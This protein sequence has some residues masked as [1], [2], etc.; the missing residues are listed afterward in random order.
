MATGARE[1][2]IRFIGDSSSLNAAAGKADQSV[3][4]LGLSLTKLAKTG[5]FAMA[6]REMERFA[7]TSFKAAV[8]EQKSQRLLSLA[9]KEVVGATENQAAVVEQNLKKLEQMTGVLDNELRPA[10]T[11]LLR[12]TRSTTEA[13]SLLGLSLDIAA[14]R[15]LD[16]NDVATT[17]GKTYLGV[18]RGV[19]TYGVSMRDANGHLRDFKDVM[20]ELGTIYQGQAKK[21]FD[22]DPAKRLNMEMKNLYESVGKGL[23][24]ALTTLSHGVSDVVGWFD[25]LTPAAQ[26]TATY[27]ALIGGGVLVASR[28]LMLFK[29]TLVGVG[30][31]V[32]TMVPWLLGITAAIAGVV[33][34]VN[35]F[36]DD[37]STATAKQNEFTAS[38]QDA[39]GAVDIQTVALLSAA[40]AA[41]TYSKSLFDKHDQDVRTKIDSTANL[42]AVLADLGINY[43]DVVSSTHSGAAATKMLGDI[44]VATGHRVSETHKQLE[45]RIP[46]ATAAYGE[47]TTMLRDYGAQGD[48]A[49][50]SNLLLAKSGSIVAIE[51]VKMSGHWGDLTA[52]EQKTAQAALDKASADDVASAAALAAADASANEA[53]TLKAEAQAAQDAEKAESD[54]NNARMS[55]VE[56]D[57]KGRA[58]TAD[59]FQAVTDLNSAHDDTKTVVNEV[60]EQQ[61]K[62]AQSALDWAKQIVD[63]ALAQAAANGVT[64]DAHAQNTLMADSLEKIASWLAPDSPLRQQLNGYIAT[65]RGTPTTAPTEVKLTGVEQA[66]SDF[67]TWQQSIHPKPVPVEINTATTQTALASIQTQIGNLAKGLSIPVQMTG[68]DDVVAKMRTLYSWLEKVRI[69]AIEAETAVSHVAD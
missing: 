32:E 28:A 38:I 18:T 47:L 17:L 42:S 51:A 41:N 55:L 69:K 48:E 8:D 60:T 54:L 7:A 62:A 22:A 6:A 12:S 35:W 10:F 39:A 15:G 64:M 3:N 20:A 9:M 63:T 24:P 52:A 23:L 61:D 34:V 4:N 29:S 65:L 59:F 53:D 49:V 45:E 40:D 56:S 44:T 37:T 50:A 33:A 31:E 11:S 5:M 1:L 26:T 13:Q 46:G 27:I 43:E 2:L 14:A 19:K 58:A 25:K 66:V 67:N 36:T 21:A 57:M 30:I 68:I 16:V